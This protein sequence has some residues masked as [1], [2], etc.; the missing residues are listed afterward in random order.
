MFFTSLINIRITS[1]RSFWPLRMAAFMS[2]W[3]RASRSIGLSFCFGYSPHSHSTASD[4][5]SHPDRKTGHTTAK[6]ERRQWAGHSGCAP[7]DRHDRPD[8]RTFTNRMITTHV[9]GILQFADERQDGVLRDPQ[10]PLRPAKGNYVVPRQII[11][12]L[13]LRPGLLLRGQPRG[14]ALGKIDL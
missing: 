9:E 6:S 10:H 7:F 8:H 3:S 2:S 12:E 5:L 14:R 4:Q 11:R 1:R 13:R